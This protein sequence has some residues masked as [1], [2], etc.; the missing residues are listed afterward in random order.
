MS[1]TEATNTNPTTTIQWSQDKKI[2][3][4][5][6]YFY[7]LALET[8]QSE[9]HVERKKEMMRASIVRTSTLM[10]AKY[11]EYGHPEMIEELPT[12]FTSFLHSKNITRYDQLIYNTFKTTAWFD[13]L[14]RLEES[15][16]IHSND[17][18]NVL[19]SKGST[20]TTAEAKEHLE[21]LDKGLK[22]AQKNPELVPHTY[23]RDLI[24]SL[25]KTR[26]VQQKSAIEGGIA[27]YPKDTEVEQTRAATMEKKVEQLK[28]PEYRIE[29][30]HKRRQEIVKEGLK[31]VIDVFSEMYNKTINEIPLQS[32]EE[33]YMIRDGFIDLANNYTSMSDDK[34]RM[35]FAGWA[36]TLQNIAQYGAEK[37]LKM[38][39]TEITDKDIEMIDEHT[40]PINFYP[41]YNKV[42]LS[43]ISKEHLDSKGV[44]I[45][46]C[47]IDMMNR[48]A[49]QSAG[50]RLF[51]Y[52]A[53]IRGIR[54]IAVSHK[55]MGT[56]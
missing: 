27:I 35:D 20:N 52:K 11:C 42:G 28:T 32:D 39:G 30:V 15:Y 45:A 33:A 21:M 55:L 38:S 48:F 17:Y 4:E 3:E 9:D 53:K 18:N 47:F 6:D 16:S 14:K 19:G 37:G 26:N 5:F 13:Q 23:K 49:W 36:K 8:E 29:E 54:A 24:E 31:A 7:E 25:D 41:K 43:Y 10:A 56:R 22:W 46:N 1:A 40:L 2:K 12:V 44:I 51:S 34:H 50:A